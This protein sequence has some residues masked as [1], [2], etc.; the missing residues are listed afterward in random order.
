MPAAIGMRER[1]EIIERRAKGASMAQIAREMRMSYA[2]VRQIWGFYQK[3]QQLEPHYEACGRREVRKEAPMYESAVA[4]K[5][6]HPTWGAGLIWTEL[7]QRFAEAGL[8]SHRTLQRWFHRAGVVEVDNKTVVKR[9]VLQRG[10]KA[11]EVWAVDAKESIRLANGTYVS[12]L[13]ISD[14]G[15]GAMLDARLFPPKTLE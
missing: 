3:H 12:W 14:E 13:A 15:S 6:A 5:Q 9:P 7:S 11:H 10:E 1:R 4:L 2:T 8:P